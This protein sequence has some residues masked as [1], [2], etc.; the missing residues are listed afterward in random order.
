[1]ENGKKVSLRRFSANQK[2]ASSW[3]GGGGGVFFSP[4]L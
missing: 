3:G 1:M 2:M 4:I